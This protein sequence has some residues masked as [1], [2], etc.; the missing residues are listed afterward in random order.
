MDFVQLFREKLKKLKKRLKFEIKISACVDFRLKFQERMSTNSNIWWYHWIEKN[1]SF[2]SRVTFAYGQENAKAKKPTVILI[3]AWANFRLKFQG[4]M[5]KISNIWWYRWIEENMSFNS[6]L[7]FAYGF[8]T[9]TV[10]VLRTASWQVSKSRLFGF[11]SL[12]MFN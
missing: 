1:V 6:R 11:K 2:N 3:S 8:G 4:Q 10:F 12:I 9:K 5:F 7:P